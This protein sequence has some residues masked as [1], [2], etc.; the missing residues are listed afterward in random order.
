M[1]AAGCGFLGCHDNTSLNPLNAW[2]L[3]SK[4]SMGDSEPPDIFQH[5]STGQGTG[6]FV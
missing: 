1:L 4:R 2:H 6:D 3:I 5:Q